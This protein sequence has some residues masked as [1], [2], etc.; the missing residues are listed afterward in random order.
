MPPTS[1]METGF[2]ACLNIVTFFY[3]DRNL[4]CNNCLLPLRWPTSYFWINRTKA[5]KY[6][7]ILFKG[8]PQRWQACHCYDVHS[9]NFQSFMQRSNTLRPC[10]SSANRTVRAHILYTIVVFLN[11]KPFCWIQARIYER[12]QQRHFCA[13]KLHIFPFVVLQNQYEWSTNTWIFKT[14]TV[15]I[16]PESGDC[17]WA[18]TLISFPSTLKRLSKLSR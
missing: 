1:V 3:H 17:P 8:S 18:Q 7:F 9:N 15:K 5:I 16:S 10:L 6:F 12:A 14:R 2:D 4:P 11:C 13:H